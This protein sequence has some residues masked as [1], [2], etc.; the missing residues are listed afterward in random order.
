MATITIAH[1][2]E[3]EKKLRAQVLLSN[4]IV[5][6]DPVRRSVTVFAKRVG[7]TRQ[8]VYRCIDEGHCPL[9]LARKLQKIF[10]AT[11]APVAELCWSKI[12]N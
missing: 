7:V 1:K 5:Q 6:N 10:G 3:A 11:A 2:T 9:P 12:S 8:Y 4:L